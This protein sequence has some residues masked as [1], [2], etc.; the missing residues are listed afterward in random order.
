MCVEEYRLIGNPSQRDPISD[1]LFAG[2]S[3]V[4][5]QLLDYIQDPVTDLHTYPELF[6]EVQ[7]Y[8]FCS[9][10][11]RPAEEEH[12][13][14]K[15]AQARGLTA[16]KP[17]Y[18]CARMRYPQAAMMLDTSVGMDFA[19]QRWQSHVW[20]ELLAH[21]FNMAELASLSLSQKHAYLYQYHPKAHFKD[22]TEEQKQIEVASTLRAAIQQKPLV[23][24]TP[25]SSM[26]AEFLKNRLWSGCVCSLPKHIF[27][28]ALHAA[29][30]PPTLTLLDLVASMEAHLL[31]EV[32]LSECVFSQIIDPH[33][34]RKHTS[35]WP[36]LLLTVIGSP[37]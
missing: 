28:L 32:D 12:K 8:S 18:T 10:V 31:D 9:V 21:L 15:H 5:K 20:K 4:S 16:G 25:V 13:R 24:S 22:R 23:A 26:M 33:P 14:V 2:E 29:A 3:V 17:A 7:E 1:K 36:T 37:S 6:I 11:E 30:R 34:E 35:V 19:I 27:E